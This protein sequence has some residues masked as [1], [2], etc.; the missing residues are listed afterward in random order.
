MTIGMRFAAS[1]TIF[2]CAGENPVVPITIAFACLKCSSVPSGRVK[3]MRT[4]ASAAVFGSE[5]I[6]MVPISWPTAGLPGTSNAAARVRPRS[7]R[8][9]S[10]SVRPMRPPAPAIA[11]LIGAVLRL[12]GHHVAVDPRE[13]ALLEQHGHPALLACALGRLPPV[14]V[15]PAVGVE[16]IGHHRRAEDEAHLLLG[17]SGLQLRHHLLRDVIALLDID[18]VG[19]DAGYARHEAAPRGDA[20]GERGDGKVADRGAAQHP[21]IMVAE[22]TARRA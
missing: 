7:A 6:R 21:P 15:I 18:P 20:R 12:R 9:A 1:S 8:T 4:S 5:A 17:H 14:D 19:R 2:F 13:L 11:I 10:I 22:W 3:S 16:N